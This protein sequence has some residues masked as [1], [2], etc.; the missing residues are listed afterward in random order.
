MTVLPFEQRNSRPVVLTPAQIHAVLVKASLFDGR[1]GDDGPAEIDIQTWHEAAVLQRWTSLPLALAAVVDYYSRP[2]K[3]G[4]RLWLMPGHV[5]EYLRAQ[6]R[7]PEPIAEQQERLQ[8]EA[9][10]PASAERRAAL[11]AAVAAMGRRKSMS[12][13]SLTE[14]VDEA[15]A[16][17]AAVEESRRAMWAEV[18]ACSGCDQAGMRLDVPTMVC[19]HTAAVTRGKSGLDEDGSAGFDHGVAV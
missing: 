5:T 19:D 2:A 8:I 10:P 9:A 4:E 11:M 17:K 3:Q 16:A 1:G 13:P 7:Q 6:G 12:E 18:D 15:A 14:L